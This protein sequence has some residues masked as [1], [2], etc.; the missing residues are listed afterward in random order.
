MHQSWLATSRHFAK[1]TKEGPVDSGVSL[2]VLFL[3]PITAAAAFATYV[4]CMRLWTRYERHHPRKSR[5]CNDL[6]E[7]A[8]TPE[9]SPWILRPDS[10]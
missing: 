7:H 1:A 8:H 5:P 10:V 2:T 3:V 9:E 4:V 6:H